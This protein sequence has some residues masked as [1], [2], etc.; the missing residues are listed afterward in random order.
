MSLSPC[1]SIPSLLS[2]TMSL[3]PCLPTPSPDPTS[4]NALLFPVLPAATVPLPPGPLALSLIDVLVSSALPPSPT[5]LSLTL[6]KNTWPC[7]GCA[8]TAS[9]TPSSSEPLMPPMAE[10]TSML[11]WPMTLSC[12]S[13]GPS[14]PWWPTTP[15]Y[16]SRG[17]SALRLVPTTALNALG[18]TRSIPWWPTTL[19]CPSRWPHTAVDALG[20]TRTYNINTIGQ[21]RSPLRRGHN[22]LLNECR[23]RLEIGKGYEIAAIRI[24]AQ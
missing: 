14:A 24:C 13:R 12:S 1:S 8:S 7:P 20:S 17:L 6:P 5:T 16:L 15:S 3:S 23:R 9:A 21:W 10:D 11:W 18:G 4:A 22:P 2:T 19:P